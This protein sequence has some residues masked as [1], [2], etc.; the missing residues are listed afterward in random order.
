MVVPYPPTGHAPF[1]P[2][3]GGI[4]TIP[5]PQAGLVGGRGRVEG[6]SHGGLLRREEGDEG[7]KELHAGVSSI[8]LEGLHP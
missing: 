6:E 3:G 2:T 4:H 5:L 7:G 1:A 8:L